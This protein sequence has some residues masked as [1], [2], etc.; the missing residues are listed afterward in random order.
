MIATED[1]SVTLSVAAQLTRESPSDGNT[2]HYL[3]AASNGSPATSMRGHL[4]AG[5]AAAT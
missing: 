1:V 5:L 2:V 3:P 4:L